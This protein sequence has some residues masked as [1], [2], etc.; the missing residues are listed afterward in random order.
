MYAR[1]VVLAHVE[2][3]LPSGQSSVRE[4]IFDLNDGRGAAFALKERRRGAA[5]YLEDLRLAIRSGG[6]GLPDC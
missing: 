5:R 2:A 6:V 4:A 3:M 1:G